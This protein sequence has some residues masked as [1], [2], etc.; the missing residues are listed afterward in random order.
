MLLPAV[1]L[2]LNPAETQLFSTFNHAQPAML[3]TVSIG[4]STIHML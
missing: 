2:M 1:K 4:V 3:R